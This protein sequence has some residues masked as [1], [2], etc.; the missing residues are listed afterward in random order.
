MR[1]NYGE[2]IKRNI[3]AALEL[4]KDIALNLPV[5]AVT[6]DEELVVSNHR[7][8]IEYAAGHVRLATTAGA[9]RIF[10]TNLVLKEISSEAVAVSGKIDKVMWGD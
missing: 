1:K 2:K 3:V 8:L 10:G 7:G 9:V 5:V 4:P 6:G